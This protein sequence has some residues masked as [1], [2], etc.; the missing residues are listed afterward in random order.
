MIQTHFVAIGANLPGPAGVSPRTTCE[1]AAGEVKRLPYVADLTRGRWYSSGPI[2]ASDQPRYIN[3]MV[4]FQA[5]VA[6][7]RL[8]ADLQAIEARAGRVR[9]AAN[10]PRVLDLDIIDMNALLRD[11]PDPILPHPRTHQRAFVLLPLRDLAP[12]WVHPRLGDT[13]GALIAALP[14]QDIYPVG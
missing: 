14:A 11:G 5:D 10:A 12:H 6:P 7:A 8:L 9:G 2:P 4:R 1:I 3:G 13:I